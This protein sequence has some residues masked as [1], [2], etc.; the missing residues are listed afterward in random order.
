MKISQ[1]DR[2]EGVRLYWERVS[3]KELRRD[4]GFLE[5]LFIIALSLTGCIGVQIEVWE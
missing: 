5:V 3:V 2:D 4:L 1:D